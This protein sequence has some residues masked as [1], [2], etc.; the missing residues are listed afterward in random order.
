MDANKICANVDSRIKPQAVTLAK[1]LLFIAKK[2]EESKAALK[3]QPIVIPY[4]NGG[5]Q[6]GIRENPAYA[7]YEKLLTSYTKSLAA[8]REM[9]GNGAQEEVS[10][11]DDLRRKF[12]VVR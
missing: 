3:D 10:A 7:A 12:K 8:L 6:V 2:L 11:L 4:D 9:I 1:Q 5:G